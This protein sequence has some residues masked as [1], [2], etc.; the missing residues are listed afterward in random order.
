MTTYAVPTI[1]PEK[2]HEVWEQSDKG[3]LRHSFFDVALNERQLRTPMSEWSNVMAEDFAGRIKTAFQEAV[4]V[5]AG[6]LER[7]GER[8]VSKPFLFPH[9]CF[10]P[11]PGHEDSRRFYMA[12]RVKMNRPTLLPIDSIAQMAELGGVD[13]EAMS[14]EFFAQML[15]FTEGNGNTSAEIV[16]RG[17]RENS[18]AEK[19][20]AIERAFNRELEDRLQHRPF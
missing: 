3:D 4:K 1:I 10:V 11:E 5:W 16:G 15:G 8:P 18:D 7:E 17:A 19:R 14:R 9:A 12:A 2:R 6:M 20:A 13:D